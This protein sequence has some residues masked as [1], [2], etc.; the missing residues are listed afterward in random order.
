MYLKPRNEIHVEFIN[1]D[2]NLNSHGILYNKV[3]MKMIREKN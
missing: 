3:Y 2:N 1:L